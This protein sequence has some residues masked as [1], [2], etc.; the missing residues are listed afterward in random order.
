PLTDTLPAIGIFFLSAGILE[1]DGYLILTG[2]LVVIFT[3]VYFTLITILGLKYLFN[4][5]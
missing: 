2:Y 5:F 4:G 1:C 3:A